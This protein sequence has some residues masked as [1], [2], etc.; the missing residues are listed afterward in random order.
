MTIK[1]LHISSVAVLPMPNISDTC[2]IESMKV[3]SLD[4]EC[5]LCMLFVEHVSWNYR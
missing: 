2:L 5:Q 3:I 1:I 4:T